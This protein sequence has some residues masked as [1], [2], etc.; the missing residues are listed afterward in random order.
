MHTYVRTCIC[1]LHG[2]YAA[3]YEQWARFKLW[4]PRRRLLLTVS[5]YVYTRRSYI[6]PSV[7]SSVSSYKGSLYSP[8]K[9][10]SMLVC[11]I[12]PRELTVGLKFNL[13]EFLKHVKL[14][15]SH[16]PN[17]SITCGVRGCMR[18]FHNY[19]TFRNHL[20]MYH[21]CDSNLSNDT[22]GERGNQSSDG[23]DESDEEEDEQEH[24]H[25]TGDASNSLAVRDTTTVLQESSALFLMGLKEKHKLTQVAMEGIIEGV[26]SL[27]QSRMDLL[28]ADISS[29]L[30]SAGIPR[31]T[32]EG[33][34]AAFDENGMYC[35]PFHGLETHHQQ[36]KFYYLYCKNNIFVTSRSICH[37]SLPFNYLGTGSYFSWQ[38][39]CVEGNKEIGG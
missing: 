38:Q 33:L 12:C 13:T 16:Q 2:T 37:N 9:S 24:E 8:F 36:L 25:G 31:S 21:S 1:T 17:F 7:A 5:A 20:Y 18:S 3:R 6:Y 30:T 22:S 19:I 14:F 15:H 26:T 23:G 27:V 4:S 29:Q 34:R 28:Y 10:I 39:K 35:R 32:I 11:P